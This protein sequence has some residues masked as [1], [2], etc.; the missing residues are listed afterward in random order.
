MEQIIQEKI[1]LFRIRNDQKFFAKDYEE[2]FR[3]INQLL[4]EER[5][6]EL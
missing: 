3:S 2:A 1:S 5:V 6:S 4:R